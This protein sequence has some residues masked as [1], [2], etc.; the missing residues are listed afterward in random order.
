MYCAFIIGPGPF[1]CPRIPDNQDQ[2]GCKTVEQ[3][4]V[5]SAKNA[6][7]HHKTDLKPTKESISLKSTLI[8]TSLSR[9]FAKQTSVV[10]STITQH[11]HTMEPL[12]GVSQTT[13]SG[14][15]MVSTV[16][17]TTLTSSLTFPLSKNSMSEHNGVVSGTIDPRHSYFTWSKGVSPTVRPKAKMA[18][19]ENSTIFTSSLTLLLSTHSFPKKTDVVRST[20]DPHYGPPT[21]SVGTSPTTRSGITAASSIKCLFSV[22]F[23]TLTV[24]PSPHPLTGKTSLAYRTKSQNYYHRKP[25]E[26][27]SKNATIQISKLTTVTN[28]TILQTSLAV[29]KQFSSSGNSGK[30]IS[31]NQKSY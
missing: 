23:S 5:F 7:T 4:M 10:T 2:N 31:L 25:S 6:K 27:N 30:L 9:S 15:K 29:T 3:P 11:Y 24:S 16:D 28:A 8:V 14:T 22:S 1:V 18:S 12:K 26:S 13:N 17:S 20:K 21:P 19:I